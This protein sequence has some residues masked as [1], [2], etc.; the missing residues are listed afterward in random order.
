MQT[1]PSQFSIPFSFL[2]F[3]FLLSF[4]SC[5]KDETTLISSKITKEYTSEVIQG[6]NHVFIDLERYA[7]GF[8]PC[9]APRAMAYIV[10]PLYVYDQYH[11]PRNTVNP[12]I[13]YYNLTEKDWK[14][15]KKLPKALFVQYKIGTHPVS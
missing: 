4:T 5:K 6:W 10:C 11:Q 8:R 7:Q 9:P 12:K 14:S 3:I 13:V 1:T 15:V 2:F